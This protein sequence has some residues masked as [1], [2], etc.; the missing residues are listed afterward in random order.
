MCWRVVVC[1]LVLQGINATRRDVSA[2]M[3]MLLLQRVDD[4]CAEICV[5]GSLV[6]TPLRAA[7]LPVLFTMLTRSEG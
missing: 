2:A 1:T 3:V 6:C 4:M 5:L 7:V